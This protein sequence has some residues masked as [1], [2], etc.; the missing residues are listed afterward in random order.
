MGSPLE[1][2]KSQATSPM[3]WVQ[4]RNCKQDLCHAQAVVPHSKSKAPAPTSEGQWLVLHNQWPA[5]H[6]GETA[7]ADR[8]IGF[9]GIIKS[10]V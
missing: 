9:A 5:N 8:S 2:Q 10:I 6:R 1:I 3:E 7:P 4:D